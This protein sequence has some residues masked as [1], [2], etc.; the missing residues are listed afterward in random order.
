M[1]QKK[2]MGERYAHDTDIA[3]PEAVV[4]LRGGGGGGRGGGGGGDGDNGGDGPILVVP[5]LQYSTLG[6][7]TTV[8]HPLKIPSLYLFYG[9]VKSSNV[10]GA[11]LQP[12]EA[13]LD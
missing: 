3:Q 9:K 10:D 4:T 11:R 8:R 2:R 12:T 5:R 1:L 6:T 13:M 7:I